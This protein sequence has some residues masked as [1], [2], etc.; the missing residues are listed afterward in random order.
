M[1]DFER[2]NMKF[3]KSF[4]VSAVFFF[5]YANIPIYLVLVGRTSR[6]PSFWIGVFA[7]VL[8]FSL[9]P[10][11]LSENDVFTITFSKPL[12]YW[13]FFFIMISLVSFLFSSQDEIVIKTQDAG[14]KAS[15]FN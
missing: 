7:V 5:F 8:L 15:L 10:R 12:L 13:T 4:H 9:M 11:L 1:R 2:S 6:P 14:E 3:I